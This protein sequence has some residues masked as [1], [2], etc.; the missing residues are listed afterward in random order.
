M[1]LVE[2]AVYNLG[3][4]RQFVFNNSTQISDGMFYNLFYILF[5]VTRYFINFLSGGFNNKMS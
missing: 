5:V 3:V 4:S 2:S 1:P